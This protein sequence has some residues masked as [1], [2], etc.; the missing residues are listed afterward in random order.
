VGGDLA[1]ETSI[2]RFPVNFLR[3]GA[4]VSEVADP[5]VGPLTPMTVKAALRPLEG[6]CCGDLGPTW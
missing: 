4:D 1:S 6:Q 5:L 2:M 3:L